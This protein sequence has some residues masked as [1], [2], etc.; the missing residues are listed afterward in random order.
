MKE[1]K[2]CHCHDHEQHDHEHEHHHHHHHHDHDHEHDCCEGGCS[3]GHEHNSEISKLSVALIICA[4]VLIGVSFLPFIAKSAVI[5]YAVLILSALL[6]G[7][8]VFLDAFKEIRKLKIG[9]HF[10]LLV[11]VIAAFCIGEA[12]EAAAV[13]LFFSI[14]E[15]FESLANARSEKSL[16]KLSEIKTD[17]ANLLK[18]TSDYETV[19]VSSVKVGDTIVVLP[20]E[21]VPVDCEVIDGSSSVDSGAITGESLPVE[22]YEGKK[23]LSGCINNQGRFTAKV[24]K[25]ASESTASR[26]VELAKDN[27]ARKG[28]S[29]KLITRFAGI[30]T[31]VVIIIGLIIAVVP[32]LVTKDWTKWI[33]SGL[34]FIVASC[35]CALV[36][37]I[38]LGF[39]SGIGLASKNAI[40]IKG[41]TFIEKLAKSSVVCVDKTGTLTDGKLSVIECKSFNGFSQ[42]EVK[43]YAFLAERS[44][45]HPIAAAIRDYCKAHSGE[46]ESLVEHSGR[47]V[48]IVSDKKAILCGGEGLMKAAGVEIPSGYPVYLSIDGALAGAFSIESNVRQ[49]SPEAIEKLKAVGIKKVVMLTGDN[50]QAAKA[51]SEKCHIDEY[52][53]GL[54]PQEKSEKLEEIS[55]EYS[56]TVYVGDGIND[57]PV[58]VQSDVGVAMGLGSEAA[59]ETADVVLMSEKI[60]DLSKAIKISRSTMRV[61]YFNIA[62]A[63]GI[64]AIVLLLAAFGFAFMSLA[65][66]A[67]VGVSIIAIINSSRLHA[68]KIK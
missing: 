12:R 34:V 68:K 36:I 2:N 64:K 7:Y 67:D 23:V 49:D 35:P 58:M 55:S 22:V 56:G 45:A 52:Y 39:F 51:V 33:K 40:I 42:D 26:I 53:C 19:D 29:E 63:L 60:S 16:R 57:V 13:S 11:A 47:G 38:P 37:S 54:L 21:R 17:T 5:F 27:A 18:G 20:F 32:S 48:E 50:E 25:E 61:V 30:Y 44:S 41:G 24:L 65:V 14:G 66:F 4:A 43:K 8:D 9:E 15:I 1:E 31:P 62:F 10:L 6:S 46:V 3:C 28:N 59:I